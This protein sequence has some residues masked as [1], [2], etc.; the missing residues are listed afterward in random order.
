MINTSAFAAAP[1]DPPPKDQKLLVWL[2]PPFFSSQMQYM[3]W[4]VIQRHHDLGVVR[5]WQDILTLTGNRLPDAV[6]VSDASIPPHLTGMEDFPCLTILYV[7]DSHIHSW[8]PHY[9]QGFDICLVSLRDHLPLFTQGRLSSDMVWWS[10]PY[11]R[12]YDRP[13]DVP[14]TK[15]WPLLFVGTVDPETTPE[16]YAFMEGLRQIIPDLHVTRGFFGTLYPKAT[17]VLNEAARGDLNF[18]VFE[19]LG[20][21][22]CLLT[23]AVGHGLSDMFT[24]GKDLF[25]YP[26]GDI[27]AVVA[28]T[29]RL[30]AD[31]EL[32]LHVAQSGLSAVDAAHRSL[33]RAQTLSERLHPL[34]IQ[35][36]AET[37]LV[38]ET[39]ATRR[40]EAPA[41]HARYLRL[42]YLLHADTVDNPA[43][44][45]AYLQAA[46]DSA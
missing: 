31:P 3:G 46:R 6:L 28:L 5:T 24:D 36:I 35:D 42:L 8:Y 44:R 30:L 7:V 27:D 26:P 9:A 29:K 39:V 14:P 38:T 12:T 23:P 13:P 2:G 45:E 11:A 20:C 25:L 22:C 34:F 10:P 21:G 43:L 41:I 1:C 4:E 15:E 33:H 40:R 32:C 37:S 18:R 17:L 16:R 19:A